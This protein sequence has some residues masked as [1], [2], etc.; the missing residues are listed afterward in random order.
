MATYV[1]SVLRSLGYKTQLKIFTDPGAYYGGLSAPDRRF[2]LASAGWTPNFPSAADVLYPLFTCP[3]FQPRANDWSN[4]GNFCSP[5]IDRQISR[6]LALET[7]D[8][9]AAS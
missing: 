6:A 3:S 4:F 7:S 1:A 5:P 8:P 2:N 9:Q